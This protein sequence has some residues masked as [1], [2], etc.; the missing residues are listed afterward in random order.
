MLWKKPAPGGRGWMK[1]WAPFL[2]RRGRRLNRTRVFSA[3]AQWPV[4]R[5][6]HLALWLHREFCGHR[7]LGRWVPGEIGHRNGCDIC[8]DATPV[9]THRLRANWPILRISSYRPPAAAPLPARPPPA[10]RRAEAG[11]RGN[12]DCRACVR[13]DS[14]TGANALPSRRYTCG[15][16][17]SA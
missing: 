11:L 2:V 16:N 15:A 1:A 8:A 14:P 9:A 10:A 4:L 13:A 3:S 12:T 6:P 5:R 17:T 7:H